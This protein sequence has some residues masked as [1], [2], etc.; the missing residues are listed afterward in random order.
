MINSY[1][2]RTPLGST[3][4]TGLLHHGIDVDDDDTPLART[5]VATAPVLAEVE[6]EVAAA[7]LKADLLALASIVLACCEK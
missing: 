2:F 3:A 7:H 4:C 1:L 6:A 5:V